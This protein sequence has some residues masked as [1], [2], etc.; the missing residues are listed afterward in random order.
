MRRMIVVT[1]GS[2]L[3]AAVLVWGASLASA[4]EPWWHLTS[5]SRPTYLAP[6]S[7][8]EI[9]VM[10]ENVGDASID[11]A[12]TPVTVTDSLPA[13]VE[14]LAIEGGSTYGLS[15][16][17]SLSCSLAKLACT[18]ERE[19]ETATGEH[20]LAPYMQ[21]EVRIK[22]RVLAGAVSGEVNRVNVSGGGAPP[23]TLSRPLIISEEP[24]PFGVEAYEFN[25]E[26]EGGTLDTQ[27]GSHPYQV[28]GTFLFNQ[29]ADSSLPPSP[30]PEPFAGKPIV[31]APALTKDVIGKLPPGLLGNAQAVPKCTLGQFLTSGLWPEEN[32]CSPQTAVGVATVTVR[33]PGIVGY[34][35]FIETLYNLEPYAGEPARF[36]FSIQLADVFVILDASVRS[37]PGE[38]YGVT[39]S[40]TN[41][42]QT[43]SLLGAQ[44]SFWGV[45]G[46]P[47]HDSVRGEACILEAYESGHRPFLQTEAAHP[48]AL[49]T[50]PTSCTGPLQ[51][52]LE[53]DSWTER[54][55]FVHLL[56]AE[57]LQTMDG[58]NRVPF[59]PTA[60]AEA[61]TD[62]A[63]APS[64]LSFNLD[65]KDEGLTSANGLAQP[66]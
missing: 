8:S 53:A 5:G 50:M 51:A 59:S 32:E 10:A 31:E 56:P 33:D 54:G 35:S 21:L 18:Y 2:L 38:D 4:A 44:L 24:T 60:S 16:Q 27:A 52:N 37:G 64:G 6:E 20:A 19:I 13:G 49:L 42:T 36:G 1:V 12:K 11:G 43:S 65:F 66:H 62:R 40:S 30:S 48:P 34:A 47:V 15:N 9:V 17:L 23:A 45:P 14:A 22:V 55:H 63:S 61:T 26:N 57:P 3:A 41:I 29:G 58:C 25:A 7:E 39:I 28:T 46:N